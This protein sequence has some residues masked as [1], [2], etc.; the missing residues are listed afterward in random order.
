MGL[1]RGNRRT[2]GR[3][4][5]TSRVRTFVLA[6][7]ALASVPVHAGWFFKDKVTEAFVQPATVHQASLSPAGR[8]LAIVGLNAV[9]DQINTSLI[10]VDTD[11][12]QSHL[13]R[14]P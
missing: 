9:G 10:V 13:V 12:G 14:G 8:H 2:S 7:L 11:T 4:G 6:A 3:R 1:E 5:M